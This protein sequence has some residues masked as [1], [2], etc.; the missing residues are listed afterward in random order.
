MTSPRNAVA[1]D[2]GR[3]YAVPG[4]GEEYISVTNVLGVIGTPAFAKSAAKRAAEC[5]VNEEAT[6]RAIEQE[7]GIDAALKWIKESP[8]RYM[9]ERGELG[10]AVHHACEHLDRPCAPEVEPFVNAYRRWLLRDQPEILAQEVTVFHPER[11]YAGT[12]DLIVRM[13][14]RTYVVDIKSGYVPKKAAL[15]TCAYAR[16]T[17]YV[18]GDASAPVPWTIDGAFVI[19]LKAKT[20]AGEFKIA[21]CDIGDESWRTFT[22]CLN[23][24]AFEERRDV[25]GAGWR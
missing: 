5:A 22:A 18:K 10:T 3:F 14:G 11:G 19:D 9:H 12:A 6:W 25:F 16:A 4:Y 20:P 8:T 21:Y 2:K 24:W 15:Q 23:L 7:E 1:T 17:H 13:G